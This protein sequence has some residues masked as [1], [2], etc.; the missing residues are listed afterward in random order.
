M[1]PK[2]KAALYIRVSTEAQREEGYSI[3]AQKEMLEAH[4]K[5]KRI[6]AYDF[7]VD[8]GF[9]GSNI[10]RPEM[11]R[12][13][14]DVKQNR[15]SHVIV[16]KLDRL[17]RSQK[18]TLYLIEDV[19]NPHNADFVS[20][21]ESLD[22]STSMGR[23]ML[24]IMSA[25]AQLE[26]EQIRERTRMGM[27]ERVK[28]GLW[29]GG[30]RVP[31][32]YDYDRDKGILVP[33]RDAETV[34]RIYELYLQG[35]SVNRVA[36]MVGLKYDRLA[37]QILTRKTNIGVICY[38][39][40]EY[41]GQHQPIIDAET[42]ERAMEMMRQ[43]SVQRTTTTDNL[44]TGL[45]ECGRCGAKMRYQK[46]GK[47]GHK[48]VCYSQ[49]KT[50]AYLI[51]DPDCDNEKV[52]ADEVEDAVVKSLFQF[53]VD[54]RDPDK[55]LVTETNALEILQQQYQQVSGKI[56]RLYTLYANDGNE[57]LLETI[58]EHKKELEGLHKQMIREQE[59]GTATN[60]ARET[61]S[62][63]ESLSEVWD[64]MTIKEKQ[65]VVRWCIEKVVIKDNHVGVHFKL[66]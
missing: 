23:A 46:W 49:Q 59:R 47:N 66:L 54:Q 15:I 33:N 9:T 31:F 2:K 27:K 30:G 21:N 55:A 7:Y 57:L 35:Y 22:T 37:T 45:V 25:F 50:K 53:A 4:C 58:E 38:N 29:M 42:Y 13:I 34:R 17:S 8:G 11:Q 18:D 62:K 20:L 28:T 3:D 41:Q 43:R 32:G 56:K 65:E 64:Y 48:L 10:E 6:A 12:L 1:E 26:R 14:D 52:W 19:F 24:G 51:K 60:R 40:V 61:L 5:S 63:I 39:G 16:Y 44:L 36:E